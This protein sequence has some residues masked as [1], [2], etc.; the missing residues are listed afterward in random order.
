[1]KAWN[2]EAL[3]RDAVR[4]AKRR[5]VIKQAAIEFRQRGYHAT[6]MDDIAAALNVSKAA[7]YR[8]VK[9]KDEVLFECFM[10]SNEIAGD[11]LRRANAMQGTGADKLELFLV[12]FITDYLDSNVAGGAMIE[13]DALL[14]DQ[15]LE[16]VRGRDK[17]TQEIRMLVDAGIRDGSIADENPRLMILAFMG[18][19]NWV[20]SWFSP[21]GEYSA[22]EI[23]EK[24]S[25]ILLNGLRSRA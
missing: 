18:T 8:Y 25:A 9:S 4:A 16:V 7:L 20:P 3:D 17:V 5:A 1:M 11:A 24:I 22:R 13:I 10:Q 12:E 2:N 23:A 14:P 6:S 19:V 15:R 21:D